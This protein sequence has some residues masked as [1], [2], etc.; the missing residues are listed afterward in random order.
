MIDFILAIISV[1]I[2]GSIYA[3]AFIIFTLAL[4]SM[5]RK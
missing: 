5:N 3:A 1:A 2:T 4:E